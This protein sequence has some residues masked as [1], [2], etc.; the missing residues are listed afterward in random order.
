MTDSAGVDAPPPEKDAP[1]DADAEA[2]A[3][4][5]SERSPDKHRIRWLSLCTAGSAAIASIVLA[6]ELKFGLPLEFGATL[7]LAAVSGVFL[8]ALIT[9]LVGRRLE[10]FG[11]DRMRA[12]G[13]A[14]L[15]LIVLFAAVL[16]A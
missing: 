12:W 10:A 1:A 7:L 16:L 13:M 14:C 15:I 2:A 9:L 6:I 4:G 3:A 11:V 5:K 8:P